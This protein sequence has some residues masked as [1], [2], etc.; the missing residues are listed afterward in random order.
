M[1]E[2][3]TCGAGPRLVDH[4]SFF[5]L[6]LIYTIHTYN[7]PTTLSRPA[8][9]ASRPP[10]ARSPAPAS[11]AS[12]PCPCSSVGRGL[13]IQPTN[14]KSVNRS[15]RSVYATGIAIPTNQAGTHARTHLSSERKNV[16]L[17]SFAC[18]V[19]C[20]TKSSVAPAAGYAAQARIASAAAASDGRPSPDWIVA[21]NLTGC[22]HPMQTMGTGNREGGE[23]AAAATP[24]AVCGS[25]M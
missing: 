11:P 25:R 9:M 8:L 20:A 19:S 7:Q 24:T 16:Q 1:I 17:A 18:P 23:A 15:A 14:N 12:A 10:A 3:G 2:I 22:A 4:P 21:T 13:S 5:P 6:L